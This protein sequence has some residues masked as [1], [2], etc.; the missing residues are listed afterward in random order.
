MESYKGQLTVLDQISDAG[1]VR[2]KII[3]AASTLY[4]RK[5]FNRTTIEEISEKAG[6]SL[7]VTHH[8]VKEKSEIMRMIMEDVL[9]TFRDNLLDMI[10]GIENPEE[11][12]A[13]AMRLYFLVVDQQREKALLI[14]QK[15][16]S[17]DRASKARIMQL[18]V[19]VT[20]IFEEMINEGITLGIFK[21]VD[22]D[23]MAYNILM[24]AH[25]WVLKHWHFKHRLTLDKYT[26]LQLATLLDALRR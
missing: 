6:V 24:A 1:K 16:N 21:P 26:E 23:L 22:V 19:K 18:E 7:P 14:Y 11:K 5:G 8:Y 25:T 17:L 13:I 15:S 10:R 2:K 4:A 12:L 20:H 9:N 3:D